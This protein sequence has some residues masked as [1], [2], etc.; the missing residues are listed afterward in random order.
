MR[1]IVSIVMRVSSIELAYQTGR[2]NTEAIG[3]SIRREA[4]WGSAKNRGLATM[5]TQKGT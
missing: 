3:V 1:V 5:D 2:P 4:K